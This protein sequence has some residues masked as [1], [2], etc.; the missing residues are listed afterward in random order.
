MPNSPIQEY[1]AVAYHE[2]VGEL[3]KTL[4]VLSEKVLMTEEWVSTVK[5]SFEDQDQE[6]DKQHEM[7]NNLLKLVLVLIQ[8]G[9]DV[10]TPLLSSVE[11]ILKGFLL[12]S[13]NN[14]EDYSIRLS[15]ERDVANFF[16]EFNKGWKDDD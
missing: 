1:K 8:L 10:Q 4:D 11:K 14:H 7:I 15:L 3:R 12:H 2:E 9:G 13:K 16:N 6:L 5:Q